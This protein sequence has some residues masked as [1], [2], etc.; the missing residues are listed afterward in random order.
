MRSASRLNRTLAAL[1]ELTRRDK[2]KQRLPMPTCI[3]VVGGGAGSGSVGKAHSDVI[4][5][6]S[7]IE[8]TAFEN[9]PKNG[10]DRRKPLIITLLNSRLDSNPPAVDMRTNRE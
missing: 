10:S 5:L 2:P 4:G 9:R 8:R 3:K 1:F 7:S 6:Q